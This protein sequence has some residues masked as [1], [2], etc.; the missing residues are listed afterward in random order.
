MTLWKITDVAKWAN[1][2]PGRARSLLATLGVR[3]F[4][5]GPGRGLGLR[6]MS[7]EVVD[8]F[9]KLRQGK[10][11]PVNFELSAISRTPHPGTALKWSPRSATR[12]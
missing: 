3:P 2:T 1:L 8:A 5:L 9:E 12:A 4:D 10:Y 6:W 11:E 7:T